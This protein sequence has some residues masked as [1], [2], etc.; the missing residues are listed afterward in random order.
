M[1]VDLND[2]HDGDMVEVT[3]KGRV[4]RYHNAIA[5]TPLD[6]DSPE[7]DPWYCENFVFAETPPTG[8]MHLLQNV[9]GLKK[10][11]ACDPS[12]GVHVEPHVECIL[13]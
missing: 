8:V 9:V 10:I 3:I 5:V 2:L 11:K 6:I 1:D 13:R 7:G 12:R 4:D